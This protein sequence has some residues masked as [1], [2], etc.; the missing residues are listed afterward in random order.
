MGELRDAKVL[1]VGAS[2]GLGSEISRAL[3]ARGA[4]LAVAGRNPDRLRAVNDTAEVLT[5][6]LRAAGVP[7]ELVDAAAERLGG[8]DGLVYA[9]GVVAFG[10]VAELDDEVVDEL[11]AL[12]FLAP[13]RLTRAALARLPRGGFVANISA[14]VAEQPTRGM[15]VY[16]AAK[17]ALTAFDAVTRTEARGQGVQVID[18]RPPHTETGLAG[19]PITG[20]APALPQGLDPAAVA[21]RIVAAI[22]GNEPELAAAAFDKPRVH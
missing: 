22:V 7:Q 20:T 1:V 17:A 13:L 14:V 16:S 12:N 3:A 9:A 15:A 5:G 4:R 19:R 8:L 18:I 10:P 21:E 11:M 6:D 2:G